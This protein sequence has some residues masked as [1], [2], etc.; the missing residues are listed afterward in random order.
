MSELCESW[1]SSAAAVTRPRSGSKEYPPHTQR[2]AGQRL[3]KRGACQSGMT[4]QER[5]TKYLERVP[6]C[7]ARQHGDDQLYKVACAIANGFNLTEEQTLEFLRIYNQRCE[8]P[9]NESRLAYKA[10]QAVGATNH[11]K[12]RGYPLR[13]LPLPEVGRKPDSG[14]IKQVVRG[15]INCSVLD[16]LAAESGQNGQSGGTGDLAIAALAESLLPRM[17]VKKLTLYARKRN[18]YGSYGETAI[19]APKTGIFAHE[20]GIFTPDE[21]QKRGE[22][23]LSQGASTWKIALLALDIETYADDPKSKDAL[24]P[25]KGHIRLVS[26]A[27]SAGEIQT[28]DLKQAPLPAEV[29]RERSHLRGLQPDRASGSRCHRQ[30]RRHA[31]GSQS[32]RGFATARSPR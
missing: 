16:S 5:V 21:R 23:G 17:R 10:G 32:R 31:G 18:I 9:W 20:T 12:P 8:P 15:R 7:I 3:S 2:S 28:Y 1:R 25:F 29:V 30:G 4:L 19:L 24:D 26:L 27:D 22:N 14:G 6:P 11:G 13:K